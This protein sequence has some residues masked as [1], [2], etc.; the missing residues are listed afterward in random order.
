LKVAGKYSIGA[1]YGTT[2]TTVEECSRTTTIVRK[3]RV[4]VYDRVK[5]RS[6]TVSAGNRYVARR[7]GS[8]R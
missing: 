4:R 7:K 1:S 2:W 8:S 6:V 3:G 5:R